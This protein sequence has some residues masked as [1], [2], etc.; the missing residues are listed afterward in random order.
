MKFVFLAFFVTSLFCLTLQAKEI[1][2][3]A[4]AKI[5]S[6]NIANAKERVLNNAKLKA[7]KKGVRTFLVKKT[8]DENYQVIR[9]QIYNFNQKFINHFDIVKQDINSEQRYVEVQI[10]VDVSEEKIQQKLRQLGILH[11]KMGYKNLM[12]F[13]QQKTRGSI[14]RDHVT[15]QNIIPAALETFSE[16]GFRTFDQQTMRQLYRFFEKEKSNLLS[17]DILIAL[18]LNYNAEILVI[19]EIIPGKR[20]NL[21]G[22]LF[23]VKSTVSFSIFNTIDGK[24]IAE[25][26]V[27][28]IERSVNSPDE[29]LWQSMFQS[30]GKHAILENVRQSIEKISMFY[31][32][33][34]EI[35]QVYQIV[36]SGYSPKKE[37]Q[38]IN[39]L[40]NTE[41]FI[42]LTELEN[43]FGHLEIELVTLNRK[44]ILRRRITSDLLKQEIEVAT[45]TLPGNHLFFINPNPMEEIALPLE[46]E[47]ETFN[48][49]ASEAPSSH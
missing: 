39:Y 19:M 4:S 35:E 13:Y 41:E 23:Q 2:I 48:D 46:E 20:D 9:E 5:Y 3:T 45:K 17:V 37:R 25:I 31:K 6:E 44:S 27:E 8:I 32:I 1:F 21:K 40:E 24:Q 34:G 30:A 15:V 12:L 18:A 22:S 16:N 47:S 33:V 38:I 26:N 28:G 29:I 10:K 36:F 7:V 49:P 11:D 14:P 42:Q 43:T